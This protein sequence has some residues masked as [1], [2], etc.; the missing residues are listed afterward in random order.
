M[1]RLLNLA[2][3]TAVVLLHTGCISSSVKMHDDLGKKTPKGF[4]EFYLGVSKPTPGIGPAEFHLDVAHVRSQVTNTCGEATSLCRHGPTRLRIAC[5]PGTNE[6][7]LT[8]AYKDGPDLNRFAEWRRG[9]TTRVTVN[10]SEG[11]ITPTRVMLNVL[12]ETYTLKPLPAPVTSR[13]LGWVRIDRARESFDYEYVVKVSA[14]EP[15]QY[16]ELASMTDEYEKGLGL[17]NWG[18]IGKMYVEGTN[19]REVQ[20]TKRLIDQ[21]RLGLDLRNPRD[22]AEFLRRYHQNRP[23][24]NL[25]QGVMTRMLMT[26]KGFSNIVFLAFE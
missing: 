4:V 10:I 18:Q 2:I 12:D 6:F 14:G 7:V 16:Y 5:A 24:D 15:Q 26:G 8:P 3:I 21:A 1:K 17:S 23:N 19:M 11:R 22:S 20:E 13:G 9:S 25:P